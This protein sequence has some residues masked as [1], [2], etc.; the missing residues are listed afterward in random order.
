MERKVEKEWKSIRCP[1][2][3]QKTLLRCEWDMVVEQGRIL[4][5]TLKQI[6]CY[7]PELSMFGGTDCRWR[8]EGVIAKARR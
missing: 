6:D 5:R 3:G 8:C 1:E 2:R 7:N 4:R